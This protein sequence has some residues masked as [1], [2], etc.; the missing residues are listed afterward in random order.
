MEF[1]TSVY[2]MARLESDFTRSEVKISICSTNLAF[3]HREWIISKAFKLG[4]DSGMTSNTWFW[5][6]PI[7]N[8]LER[9]KGW[10]QQSSSISY[11]GSSIDKR[12]SCTWFLINSYLSTGTYLVRRL[13]YFQSFFGRCWGMM[14]RKERK[15][16]SERYTKSW[17]I[18]DAVELGMSLLYCWNSPTPYEDYMLATT[19]SSESKS[20]LK[21]AVIGCVR[22]FRIKGGLDHASQ[23][24]F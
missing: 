11:Q 16:A 2:W 19:K 24:C 1:D 3:G 5:Y 8:S 13:R 22:G 7:R 21:L 12:Q 17:V 14:W 6:C 15:Q 9:I 4:D 20:N 18:Q 10:D 23:F